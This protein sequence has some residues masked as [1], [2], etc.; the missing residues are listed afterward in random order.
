MPKDTKVYALAVPTVLMTYN[1]PPESER[2]RRVARFVDALF[3]KIG[4]LRQPPRHPKWKD[5]GISLNVAGLERSS[6]LRTCS[7]RPSRRRQRKRVRPLQQPKNSVASSSRKTAVKTFHNRRRPR[8][9]T[10]FC[11][12]EPDRNDTIRGLPFPAPD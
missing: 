12:G 2:Y 8:L 9:T 10:T 4:Q 3:G 5:T 1:R 11:D 7:T 6:P